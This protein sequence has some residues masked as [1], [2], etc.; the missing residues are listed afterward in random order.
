MSELNLGNFDSWMRQKRWAASLI[1]G[2]F[3]LT[4]VGGEWLLGK[5]IH[6]GKFSG[7]YIVDAT[8]DAKFA[9]VLLTQV[10]VIVVVCGFF[11]IFYWNIDRHSNFSIDHKADP[12]ITPEQRV[13]NVEDNNNE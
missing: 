10:G 3:L 5:A 13:N 9:E 12:D 6:L 7:W 2:F 1:I 8:S 4:L 11:A